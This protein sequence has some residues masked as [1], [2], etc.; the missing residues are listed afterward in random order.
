[1]TMRRCQSGSHRSAPLD[2]PQSSLRP[3]FARYRRTVNDGR[4][5][6]ATMIAA[7]DFV[8]AA[9]LLESLGCVYLA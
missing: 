9:P 1:M 5:S 7:P 8:V 3:D 4:C 6:D 2:A